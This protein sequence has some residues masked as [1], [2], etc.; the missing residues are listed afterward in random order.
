ME[1]EFLCA[2]KLVMNSMTNQFTIKVYSFDE[3]SEQVKMV[4]K[5][6]E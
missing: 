6:S 1:K 3:L 2:F 4:E 5:V